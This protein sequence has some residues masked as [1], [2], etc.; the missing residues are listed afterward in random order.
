MQSN[1]DILGEIGRLGLQE[2]V[3]VI[4]YL[5]YDD[6]PC[7]YNLARLMVFPS[8]HEGFGIPLVEAMACGCPV[9]CSNITS[10][11]EVV[12]DAALIFDPV[13]VEDMT[14]KIWSLWS[15]DSL[16]RNLKSK[17]LDRVVQFSWVTMARQTIH[18]YEK[19]LG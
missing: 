2:D 11:P 16:Q 1:E 6:L 15:D 14:E 4:G 9:T 18:V 5:P 17:G 7:L 8:L 13:A 3:I 19:A 12:G 10:I